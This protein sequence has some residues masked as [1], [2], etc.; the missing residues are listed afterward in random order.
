MFSAYTVLDIFSC[1][2][3]GIYAQNLFAFFSYILYYYYY[4]YYWWGG[5]ESPGICKYHAVQEQLHLFCFF[6]I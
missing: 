5:T 4:Y 1:L 2:V 6:S 3:C